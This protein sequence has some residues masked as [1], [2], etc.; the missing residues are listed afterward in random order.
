[1]DRYSS[2]VTLFTSLTL[3]ASFGIAMSITTPTHAEDAWC[4]WSNTEIQESGINQNSSCRIDTAKGELVLVEGTKK[5]NVGITNWFSGAENPH[6]G[7]QLNECRGPKRKVLSGDTLLTAPKMRWICSKLKSG[8]HIMLDKKSM[9]ATLHCDQYVAQN[10]T[11]EAEG[12]TKTCTI[13]PI[14]Q[15]LPA[16]LKKAN[17][18]YGLTQDDMEKKQIQRDSSCEVTTDDQTY[19]EKLQ[20]A[21]IWG[22]SSCHALNYYSDKHSCGWF[23]H[24]QRLSGKRKSDYLYVP[25]LAEVC[26]GKANE[27]VLVTEPFWRKDHKSTPGMGEMNGYVQC[28]N[29]QAK[30][31]RLEVKPL[32]GEMAAKTCAIPQ[33]LLD[34][35]PDI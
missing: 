25:K 3:I 11:L 26:K 16:H 20:F 35:K 15:E 22:K 30:N 5:Y 18:W 6:A 24:N 14:L 31:V 28:E 1:M 23:A 2:E 33:A 29:G 19:P 12:Q 13:P 27:E 34:D 7:A 17:S 32:V 10:I 9:K 8:D 4:G 21:F